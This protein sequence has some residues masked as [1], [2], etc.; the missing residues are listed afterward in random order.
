MVDPDVRAFL[1]AD[2]VV[3]WKEFRQSSSVRVGSGS[4]NRYTE[5][6]GCNDVKSLHTHDLVD[7][8]VLHDDIRRVLDAKSATGDDGVRA[9]A[10][11][12]GIAGN[13][14]TVV[15]F[16]WSDEVDDGR[17][18]LLS[19]IQSAQVSQSC[20]HTYRDSRLEGRRRRH[21]GSGTAS[22]ASYS[23]ILSR[24]PVLCE[25]ADSLRNWRGRGEEEDA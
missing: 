6:D 16:E 13:F 1:D 18:V 19:V 11:D 23:S 25:Y 8:Q 2:S 12:A 21:S 5:S 24:V 9:H 20:R 14:E 17:F 3:A 15:Q 10:D 22:T 4:S 7:D